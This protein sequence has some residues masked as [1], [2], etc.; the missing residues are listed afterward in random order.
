MYDEECSNL[1]IEYNLGTYTTQLCQY[2]FFFSLLLSVIS[3]LLH[4]INH[5]IISIF[6]RSSIEIHPKTEGRRR[7]F[8]KVISTY[9]I[10]FGPV[11]FFNF[12]LVR[13]CI[14]FQLDMYM[15]TCMYECMNVCMYVCMYVAVAACD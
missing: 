13:P 7:N 8:T 9:I 3:N 1:L 5:I 14:I 12:F 4:V 6:D 11:L 15:C 10:M 2:F